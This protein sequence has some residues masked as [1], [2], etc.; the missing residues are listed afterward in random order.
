MNLQI[1][2]VT[3]EKKWDTFVSATNT[4]A[5]FQ[6][7][8]WG[9]V[10]KKLGVKVWRLGYWQKQKLVGATQ[11]VKVVAKSGSYLHV[12]HGPVLVDY[13]SGIFQ[14][15]MQELKALAINE[16]VWFVRVS[17]M[18]EEKK[19]NEKRLRN[20]GLRPAAIHA[21]NAEYCW[22]L[23]LGPDEEQLLAGMRKTTRYEIRR[24]EKS[25]VSVQLAQ[26]V[27]DVKNF[28]ALYDATSKRQGF[29]KHPGITQEWQ[30]FH[31]RGKADLFLG[32]HDGRL[33]SGALIIYSW[34]QAIYH[35][36]ASV[37]NKIPVSY[38]LQWA[39]IREAK[40]R[41][42]KYYNFWGIAPSDRPNH[43]WSGLTLFKTGFGGRA[44]SFVHAHDLPVSALYSLPR[45]VENIRKYQKGY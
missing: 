6:S 20:L 15:V 13:S 10:Q 5:F 22:V 31:S 17:P 14:Q 18:V 39:A 21:M 23:D 44:M 4:W 45:L 40:K 9:E 3:D 16:K 8:D 19:I 11:V 12:R 35:H 1:T 26:N 24:A 27:N 36:G 34:Q 25:A 33:I 30:E 37:N 42:L 41:G 43:P 29:T 2:E 28:L 38:A 7:W 32:Y